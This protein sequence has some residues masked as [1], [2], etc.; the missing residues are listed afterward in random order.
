MY[1]SSLCEKSTSIP[2]TQFLGKSMLKESILISRFSKNA[3]KK[4]TQSLLYT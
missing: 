4:Y 2:K 3:S 1:S